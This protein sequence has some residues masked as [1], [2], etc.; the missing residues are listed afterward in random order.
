MRCKLATDK[1]KEI[2]DP[3]DPMERTLK[4]RSLSPP[5][6]ESESDSEPAPDLVQDTSA[7]PE[8][9]SRG[10]R[11]EVCLCARQLATKSCTPSCSD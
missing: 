4:L 5:A 9:M 11:V 2:V 6:S 10:Q 8:P 3:K 7:N 1:L